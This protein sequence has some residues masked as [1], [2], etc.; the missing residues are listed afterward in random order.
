MKTIVSNLRASFNG[1]LFTTLSALPLFAA[2]ASYPE[3]IGFSEDGTRF[4]FVEW[5]RQ[6]GSGFAYANLYVL[7]LAKDSWLISPIRVLVEDET[8]APRAAYEMALDQAQDALQKFDISRP[9]RLIYAAPFKGFR[10]T[11]GTITW[12]RYGA[13]DGRDSSASRQ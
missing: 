8:A 10:T 11:R 3:A 2:D 7:D 1:F 12:S 13:L 4:A 9:A 6:D 5:G